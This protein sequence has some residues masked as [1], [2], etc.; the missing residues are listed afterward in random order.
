[1]VSLK[2]DEKGNLTAVGNFATIS[3]VEA[4][5]QDLKSLLKM[6]Q[7]EYPFDVRVGIP[8][9][10]LAMNNNK[11][12]VKS[13]VIERTLEDERVRAVQSCEVVFKNGVMNVSLEV[14]LKTGETINV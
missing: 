3:N 14:L 8:Y 6:F 2:V 10:F 12:I 9:Y 4:V 7:T 5:K 11:E 1:M 13:A